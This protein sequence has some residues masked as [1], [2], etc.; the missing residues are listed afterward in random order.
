MGIDQL[1]ARRSGRLANGC[2]V[3]ISGL[4][5]AGYGQVKKNKKPYLVHRYIWE[6]A[7]GPIPAGM[8]IDHLCRNPACHNLEHLELVTART[9]TLRGVSPMAVNAAKTHCQHGHEFNAENTWVNPKTGARQCRECS[10][11]RLRVRRRKGVV[12]DD[13][14]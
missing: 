11:E 9:N 4:S 13:A 14:G 3:M 6:Q 1:I 2:V 5:S 7:Y 10:R 8:H 12:P